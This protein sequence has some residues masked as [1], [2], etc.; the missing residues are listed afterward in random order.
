MGET[1]MAWDL[2]NECLTFS[3]NDKATLGANQ[4]TLGK[5]D[6]EKPAEQLLKGIPL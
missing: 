6:F 1:Y 2:E 4:G 5:K 3:I